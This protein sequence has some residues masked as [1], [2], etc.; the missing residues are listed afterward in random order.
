M[1]ARDECRQLTREQVDLVMMAQLRALCQGDDMTQKTKTK[2]TARQRTATLFRFGGHRICLTV[3]LFLHAMSD[4]RFKAIKKSW[5][6]NGLCPR[7]RSTVLPHNTTKLSD[8]Q[9]VVRFILHYAE[10]NAILLPGR[11]P[12]YKRD[13]LQLLP[14]STTKRD[15]WERYHQAALAAPDVKAVCYSLFCELWKQLTPQVIVTRPMSDLCW[16]CQQNSNLIM[17]AHN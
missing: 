2:K 10:E 17:R 8:I 15:V 13:D 11:I 7:V 16:V 12:G 6:E 9:H 14:S 1:S 3:F 5:I 4:K